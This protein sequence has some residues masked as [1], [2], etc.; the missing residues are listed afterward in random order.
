MCF[1]E[2]KKG[3]GKIEVISQNKK[4]IFDVENDMLLWLSE[5]KNTIS[6]YP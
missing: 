4:S 6:E 3:G 1:A 2:K 5:I